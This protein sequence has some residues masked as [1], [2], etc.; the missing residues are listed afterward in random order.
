VK[1]AVR[2][3][4][5]VAAVNVVGQVAVGFALETASPEQPEMA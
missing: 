1:V 2:P 5:E 3:P 4:G